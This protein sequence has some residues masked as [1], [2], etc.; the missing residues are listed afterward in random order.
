MLDHALGTI[1]N[2]GIMAQ[3]DD[4]ADE[5]FTSFSELSGPAPRVTGGELPLPKPLGADAE[6]F[7]F[8][9]TD[10]SIRQTA[11]NAIAQQVNRGEI[12]LYV[13]G[14]AQLVFMRYFV[15]F[16]TGRL[17]LS[18]APL[19]VLFCLALGILFGSVFIGLGFWSRRDPLLASITALC[20]YVVANVMDLLFVFGFGI[21]LLPSGLWFWLIRVLLVVFLIDAIRAAAAYKRIVNKMIAEMR[22]PHV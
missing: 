15:P 4:L 19:L 22:D 3:P 13:I 6:V 14:G 1:D 8:T 2:G 11:E 10:D 21:M 17:S 20:V 9:S 18:D 16:N 5:A 12:V 7:K